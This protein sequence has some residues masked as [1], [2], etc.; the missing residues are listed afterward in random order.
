M[1]T[2]AIIIATVVVV[3]VVNTV[4]ILFQIVIFRGKVINVLSI[5][6]ACDSITSAINGLA[7]D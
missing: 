7:A 6:S 3:I 4:C 1:T 5:N 2:L